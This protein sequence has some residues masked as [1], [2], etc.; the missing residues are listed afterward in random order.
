MS[1]ADDYNRKQVEAGVLTVQHVTELVRC[2]QQH[3]NL[4]DDGMAGPVTIGTLE[5]VIRARYGATMP[6][7]RCWPLRELPDG[8]KPVV[9]SGFRVP[10]RPRHPGCD[11]FYE[12]RAGDPPMKVGDGGRENKWW[13][14]PGT[15]AVAQADGIVVR[16]SKIATGFRYAIAHEGGYV[17]LG[18]HLTQLFVKEGDHVALGQ[19]L[20]TVGDNPID[21][22]A[23]HLHTELH[24]GPVDEYPRHLVNPEL[25]WH[26]AVVLPA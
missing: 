1:Q 3:H 17:T 21:T 7:A 9:T 20:G 2:W 24:A 18:M 13:I 16:A 6:A 26:G 12:R 11:L 14:P 4:T 25:F 22:D 15:H 10:D 8:R 5:K 19:E 23:I